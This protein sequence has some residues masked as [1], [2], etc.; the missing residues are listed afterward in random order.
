LAR[1]EHR[2]DIGP[3][4]IQGLDESYIPKT[5]QAPADAGAGLRAGSPRQFEPPAPPK[6]NFPQ[7]NFSSAD[8]L[9]EQLI[10]GPMLSFASSGESSHGAAPRSTSLVPR[11]EATLHLDAVGTV[12]DRLGC[13]TVSC[14]PPLGLSTGIS[15]ILSMSSLDAT[16]GVTSSVLAMGG[17]APSGSNTSA[18]SAVGALSLPLLSDQ[19]DRRA[20]RQYMW[21]ERYHAHL[22]SQERQLLQPSVVARGR[23][24]SSL[25]D[26]PAAITTTAHPDSLQLVHANGRPSLDAETASFLGSIV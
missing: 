17:A 14:A 6:S 20:E 11:P 4:H 3:A 13:S 22:A 18:P 10:P 23:S 25:Y 1:L 5:A 19:S 2:Q 26:A 21:L 8:P 15:R 7:S 12:T 16:G 9:Q 24:P